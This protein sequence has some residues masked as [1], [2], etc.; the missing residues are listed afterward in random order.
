[1]KHC[2]VSKKEANSAITTKLNNESTM[3]VVKLNTKQEEPEDE[4]QK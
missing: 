1:M 3:M 2:G 4:Q